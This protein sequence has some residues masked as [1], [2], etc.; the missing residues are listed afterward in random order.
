MINNQFQEVMNNTKWEEIREAMLDSPNVHQWRTKDIETGY[1]CPWD[2]EWFYHFRIG[3]YKCIE[4]LEIKT[5]T[6]E[7]RNEVLEVLKCIYVPGE[8][9]DDVIR[10]YGYVEIGKLVDYL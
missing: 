4:W 7:I 5:E 6:Q 8:A 1:I 2:D 3:G 10:V 9:L